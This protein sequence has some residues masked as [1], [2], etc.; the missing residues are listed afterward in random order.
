M[1]GLKSRIPNGASQPM[2]P[3][4]SRR[5]TRIER[6]RNQIKVDARDDDPSDRVKRCQQMRNG[7]EDFQIKSRGPWKVT[8]V[9]IWGVE[10]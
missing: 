7:R 10:D 6:M 4:T 9:K 1:K 8:W 5:G 2:N 3:N